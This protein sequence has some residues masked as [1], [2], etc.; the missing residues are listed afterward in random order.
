MPWWGWSLLGL[1]LLGG[2]VLT[3]GGFFLL[4]FGIGA[5]VLGLAGLLGLNGP[6]WLQWLLFSVLS[7]VSLVLIRPRVMGRLQT[8]DPNRRDELVGEI[9]H[10]ETP[11]AP[12]QQGRGELRGSTWTVENVGDIAL[13]PGDRCAVQRVTGLVLSIRK[14][15]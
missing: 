9:V 7:V 8:G 10:V 3:P 4:F 2:E 1:V 6:V 11:I 5:L 13:V 15:A 12:G 14:E